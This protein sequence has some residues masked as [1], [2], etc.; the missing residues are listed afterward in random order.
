[1]DKEFVQRMKE[2]LL[3]MKT[4]ILNNLAAESEEFRELVESDGSK[5]L[6]DIASSDI[7]RK[8]IET[9]GAQEY[10]RLELIDSALSRIENGRYGYDLKTGEPIPK[11]RLEAIPYALYTIETQKQFE[12][13][14]R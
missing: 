3:Q 6:V 13:Q 12:R 14:R 2:K 10:R 4:E 11:E 9:L 1:M 7:D 8:T 5:D